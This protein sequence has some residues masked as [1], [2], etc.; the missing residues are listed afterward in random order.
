MRAMNTLLTAAAVIFTAL[1]AKPAFADTWSVAYGGTID[2]TYADG[3]VAKGYVNADHTYSIALPSG[4]TIKGNWA[5]A[6]GQSCFTP[7]DPPPAPDAKPVCV[8]SKEYNAGDSFA[9]ED[10]TGKFTG[11]IKSGR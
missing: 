4:A 2:F 1:A 11:V 7:T 6:N 5:E 3:R 8:P 9:G 10:A